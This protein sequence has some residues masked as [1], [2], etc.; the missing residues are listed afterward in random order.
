MFIMCYVLSLF[1]KL[2]FIFVLDVQSVPCPHSALFMLF[3]Q[4]IMWQYTLFTAHTHILYIV[5]PIAQIIQP[6]RTIKCYIKNV[7]FI[8]L[9][10][11]KNIYKMYLF[12]LFIVHAISIWMRNLYASLNHPLI[13]SW[14]P[15]KRRK[16]IFEEFD[17]K[18]IAK[19]IRYSSIAVSV[20]IKVNKCPLLM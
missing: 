1:M 10:F 20:L 4:L 3:K 11:S 13:L 6:P 17:I 7:P 9:P 16:N 12:T 5:H 14:H 18:C 8:C 19:K 15:Q 2:V